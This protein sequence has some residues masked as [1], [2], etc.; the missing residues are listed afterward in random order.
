MTMSFSR[1]SFKGLTHAASAFRADVNGNF[2]VMTG[3]ML[4]PLIGFSSLAIDRWKVATAKSEIENAAD[5]AALGAINRAAAVLKATKDSNNAINA[6]VSAGKEQF[7]GNV[8]KIPDATAQAPTVTLKI[9]GLEI[10]ASVGWKANVKTTF[11]SFFDWSNQNL[12]GNT[13]SSLTMPAYIQ[14]HMLVDNSSSMGIGATE[15]AQQALYDKTSCAIACHLTG[16]NGYTIATDNNID[17]RI[18]VVRE[19]LIAV[20]EKTTARIVFPNQI[21]FGVYT[22]SNNLVPLVTVNSLES[23]DMAR[24]RQVM[25]SKLT[26]TREGG[27]TD[28]H[29]ALR[30]LPNYLPNTGSGTS[31]SDPI[32]YTLF[33]TDGVEH[34]VERQSTGKWGVDEDFLKS[35]GPVLVTPH[36]NPFLHTTEGIYKS[37]FKYGSLFPGRETRADAWIQALDPE[38]CRDL[39]F[40]KGRLLTLEIEYL[41]PKKEFWVDKDDHVDLRF[42]WV[43]SNLQVRQVNNQSLSHDRFSKCASSA[44]DA[45]P[46]L[47]SAEI[48]KAINAMFAS[49]APKPPRLLK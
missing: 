42:G 2:A 46:A 11:G 15:E 6:G 41:I 43:K 44:K 13:S 17:T 30:K 20:A 22:F 27:G 16:E 39:K 7:Q 48:N 49:I 36:S 14:I 40:N 23:T 10:T 31:V 24:L 29:T 5:A 8:G 4:V 33:I 1:F 37:T 21:K 9:V 28:Y 45:Y 3:V 38:L 26:L 25:R 35:N 34:P 18:D 19:A 12:K 47:T 32:V